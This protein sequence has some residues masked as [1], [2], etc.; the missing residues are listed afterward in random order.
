MER[1]RAR[2]PPPRPARTGE[3]VAV[4]AAVAGVK[5]RTWD[6]PH[7]HARAL[8]R[9]ARPARRLKR[10]GGAARRCR[11]AAAARPRAAARQP[12]RQGN[13]PGRGCCCAVAPSRVVPHPAHS[14]ISF[15]GLSVQAGVGAN[16]RHAA[17]AREAVRR[18]LTHAGGDARTSD[19]DTCQ[20]P[21]AQLQEHKH[22][23]RASSRP[24]R[25]AQR[26]LLA[27]R[28]RRKLLA[29]VCVDRTLAERACVSLRGNVN[30]QT[31]GRAG[32]RAH[33]H[34]LVLQKV[35]ASGADARAHRLRFFAA[36]SAPV[37]P[38]PPARGRRPRGM[39]RSS[40]W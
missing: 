12:W 37:R 29:A 39:R 14:R 19:A 24:P 6:P 40:R 33:V 30:R 20:L 11:A 27:A 9:L 23:Q 7:A 3:A 31:R 4:R 16:T 22:P 25:R 28:E 17:S 35:G 2:R 13:R 5:R 36:L 32:S 38:F 15:L 8:G 10:P 18:R 1:S 34:C 21:G 26:V